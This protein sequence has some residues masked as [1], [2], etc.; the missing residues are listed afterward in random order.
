MIL[1]Y[2]ITVSFNMTPTSVITMF[3]KSFEV[4]QKFLPNSPYHT[5]QQEVTFSQQTKL[6]EFVD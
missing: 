6:V 3:A 1:R 4:C 5:L 2:I